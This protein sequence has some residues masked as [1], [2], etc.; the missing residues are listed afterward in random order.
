MPSPALTSG[1]MLNILKCVHHVPEHPSTM[2][3]VYTA[4][5]R[6]CA[7]WNPVPSPV[8]THLPLGLFVGDTPSVNSGQAPTSPPG[9]APLGTRSVASSVPPL[10]TWVIC[11]GHPF[12][13]LRAGS[14]VP[15]RGC[16]PWN[17]VPSP[18]VSHPLATW[19]ICGGH[20][21]GKLR[22]GSHAPARGLRPLEPRSVA[23]SVPPAC[24]WVV[25]GGHPFGKLR[26]GSHAPARGLRPLEPRSVACSVPPACHLGCLWGTPLR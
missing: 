14:H 17:P 19:V 18:L 26:A 4:P 22:A 23:C 25:C 20:P 11:G 24:H 6:G 8:V 5:A 15:A 13:K 3:P 10:A 16:A 2:Y 7:P 12:G 21:F 1:K 9:A